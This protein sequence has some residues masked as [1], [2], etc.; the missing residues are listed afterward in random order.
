[1]KS[2][3]SADLTCKASVE[4]ISQRSMTARS[5]VCV[6]CSLG[7]AIHN[8]TKFRCTHRGRATAA[9]PGRCALGDA[10]LL[11]VIF[12][13]GCKWMRVLGTGFALNVVRSG[14]V[15]A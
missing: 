11:G 8:Q 4:P 2:V 1:M 15:R 5:Y 7:L 9:I 10:G 14:G 12:A 3:F 13:M 6:C